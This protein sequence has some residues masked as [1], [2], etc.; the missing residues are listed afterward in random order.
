MSQGK[1]VGALL[2]IAACGAGSAGAQASGDE[3]QI[4]AARERFNLAIA[5]HDLEH[6]AD[7]WT[8]SIRVITS[9]GTAT[10]GRAAYRA[11][12]AAGIRRHADER[13]RRTPGVV[14]VLPAWDMATESGQWQG[15]WTDPDGPVRVTGRYLAQWRR[16]DGR[17]RLAAES[18]IAERCAG[19]RYCR[20]P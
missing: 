12:F 15:D 17:W 9:R 20:E 18:F 10:V 3:G 5:R 19:G 13:Y 8:D 1:I 6:L 4:R 7:D 11:L 14:T 2:L 16:L